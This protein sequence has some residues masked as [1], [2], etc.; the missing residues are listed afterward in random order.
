MPET[1]LMMHAIQQNEWGGVDRLKLVEMSRPI[2]LPTEVLVKVKAAGINPVDVYTAQ[3][4]A[5]MRAL[6]LPYVPGWDVAGIVEQV[7]YGTTRFKVGDEVFGMPW[8]PRAA[9]AYAE[10]LV[11]PARH[12][13]LKPKQLSFEQAAALPLAGLTAWEML[14]DIANVG[15]GDRV[16]INGA[17]GGVGHLAVQ[18]AKAR[19]AHVVAVASGAKH[20]FLRELGADATIDYTTGAVSDHVD[21]ADVVIELVGGEI[22]LQM[23][24][25]LRSG[26]LLISAQSAWAPQLK[27]EAEKLGV[28]TS[29]YLVEPNHVG[30]EA[31][32]QMAEQGSLRV[33]VT[34]SYPLEN[35]VEA[36]ERVAGRRS[37][38]KVVLTV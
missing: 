4:K 2:P 29:W 3:G 23:L 13:A 25:T 30:L 35:A 38:G 11:A 24:K 21:D 12:L 34:A 28:R 17:G 10:Y 15:R 6:N 33:E 9:S 18:I 26:G 36:M 8:F 31:L 19:G 32:A 16:L 20:G 7:G 14:V 37:T 1:Q 22:C 5:Y 27:N